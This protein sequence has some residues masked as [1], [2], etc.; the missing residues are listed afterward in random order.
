MTVLGVLG[1]GTGLSLGTRAGGGMTTPYT[2]LGTCG[3]HVRAPWSLIYALTCAFA[4]LPTALA[5]DLAATGSR[6]P[7]GPTPRYSRV[8]IP[9]PRADGGTRPQEVPSAVSTE[10]LRASV[11]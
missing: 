10:L 11:P 6:F 1:G 7:L 2:R 4:S 3:L 5:T 9:P 8:Q